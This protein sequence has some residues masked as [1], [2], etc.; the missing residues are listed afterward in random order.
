MGRLNFEKTLRNMLS[1][2]VGSVRLETRLGF[3][4]YLYRYLY[5][6]PGKPVVFGRMEELRDELLPMLASVGQ[7]VSD[8]MRWFVEREGPRNTRLNPG[9]ALRRTANSGGRR[10]SHWPRRSHD[11]PA[12]LRGC[13]P[14]SRTAPR[15]G[16]RLL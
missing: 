1:L 3:Y 11:R 16:N 8:E 10:I 15:P 5:T 9:T 7:P 12:V 6:E 14:C 13:W 2:G 4:T